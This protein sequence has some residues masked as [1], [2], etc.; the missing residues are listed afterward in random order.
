MRVVLIV[1]S[2]AATFTPQDSTEQVQLI[3]DLQRAFDLLTERPDVD[4]ARLAFVGRSYGAAMV[5]LLAAVEHRPR[6]YVLI[7]GDGGLVT[8]YSA[9]GRRAAL[10]SLSPERRER[11][12][13]AMRPIEP[14]RY[15]GCAKGASFFFQAARRDELV[16]M[17]DAVAFQRAAPKPRVVSWYDLDHNLGWPAIVDELEWLHGNLGTAPAGTRADMWCATKER[18]PD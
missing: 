13:A 2:L 18:C 10:D 6:T 17:N 5:G 16:T 9:P 4:A 7:V 12:L 3:V 8:H 1:V 11:W 15:I 14:I